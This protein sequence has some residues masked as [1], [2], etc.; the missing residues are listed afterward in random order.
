ML[1]LAHKSIEAMLHFKPEAAFSGPWFR[2]N[3]FLLSDRLQPF[4]TVSRWS[5]ELD[6]DFLR[7]PYDS[8]LNTA[9]H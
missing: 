9:T 1:M 2:L 7:V 4:K 3:S 6:L 8:N 5:L